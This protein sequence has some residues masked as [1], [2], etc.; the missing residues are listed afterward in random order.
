TPGTGDPIGPQSLGGQPIEIAAGKDPR[1]QVWEWMTSPDNPYFARAIVNRVWAHYFKRGLLEPVDSQS[2][3]NPP[4][5]PEA[6]D[7]VSRGF[8]AAK[9]DWR[10]H[11]R[12]ILHLSAFARRGRTCPSDAGDERNFSHRS[13]QR[14]S[15]ELVVNSISQI[16]DTRPA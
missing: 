4:S 8:V 15:A 6:L 1:R 11:P 12:R 9:Y 16:A 13:L 3:A 10:Q 7:G 14:V 5:H 2:A